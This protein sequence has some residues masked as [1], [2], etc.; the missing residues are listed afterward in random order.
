[1]NT[2]EYVDGL[3]IDLKSQAAS[4]GIPLSEVAWQAAI[5]CD[6]WP[7]VYGAWGALCTVSERKKRLGYSPSHTSIRTSCKAFDGGTCNGCKWYPDRFR[8][9]CFDC[10]GFTK[11]VIEQA[12]G[13]KL[14]GDMV[15]TQWNHA[16]NWCAKGT[17]AQGIPQH[18][19]V[20]LFKYNGEKWTHTGLYF[21][22]ETCEAASGVQHKT[23]MGSGWTHWAVAKPFERELNHDT[24]LPP[25]NGPV[26]PPVSG[27]DK[28]YYP[29]LRRGDKGQKVRELQTLLLNHGYA[30]PKYG[31]DGDFGAETE[32]AVK[33][34]QRD[35]GLKEDGV[36]GPET[37]EKLLTAPDKPKHYQ[38]TITG[39]SEG[40]ADDLVNKYPGA[41]KKE[42]V[43]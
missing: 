18:V 26:E 31:A 36:V 1:M 23:K 33:A 38:V 28:M 22:G 2:A 19:L 32:K 24:S 25:Q 17:V 43:S 14:Y 13:F 34:C 11:W 10:R 39:L 20:C 15:L 42:M 7:Y 9:R 21:N 5:A 29:T 3:I 35:W 41:I 8:T 30:L 4:A 37:W 6:G 27:D 40:E 12:T 16:D